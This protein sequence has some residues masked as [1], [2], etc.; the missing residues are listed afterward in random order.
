MKRLNPIHSK[1]DASSSAAKRPRLS[2]ESNKDDTRLPHLDVS[3]GEQRIA[4]SIHDES[5]FMD[6]L[7]S[8]LD[9]SFFNLD[10]SPIKSQ[11]AIRNSTPKLSQRSQHSVSSQSNVNKE[12]LSPKKA[13]GPLPGLRVKKG[14]LSPSK[15]RQTPAKRLNDSSPTVKSELPYDLFE[16]RLGA[17]IAQMADQ[18]SGILP[19]AVASLPPNFVELELKSDPFDDA[20]F[21]FDFGLVDLLAF[22][23]NVVSHPAVDAVSGIDVRRDILNDTRSRFTTLYFIPPFRLRHW[24]INLPLG[25]V[26]QL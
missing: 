21:E 17:N 19:A 1:Q 10:S 2:P 13:K 20:L 9:A 24:G 8:G 14:P 11:N 3:N 23:E 6:D 15:T 22:D 26:I 18:R 12:V 25:L 4:P 16:N 5:A 7:M